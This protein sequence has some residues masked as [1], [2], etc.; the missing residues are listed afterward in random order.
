MAA[1]IPF[2]ALAAT[3]ASTAFS[4]RAQRQQAEATRQAGIQER[5]AAERQAGEEVRVSREEAADLRE[6]RRRTLAR[7]RSQFAAA[8]V[9]LSGSPLE[10]LAET[11]EIFGRDINRVLTAGSQ[12]ASIIRQQ[13][14][15][16]Q[17]GGGRRASAI[18]LAG[19]ASGISQVGSGLQSFAQSRRRNA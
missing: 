10:L 14:R 9:N 15:A 18:R 7:Q 1:A 8:G 11:S 3:L 16:A 12:R 2:I 5:F 17:A 4:V 13:G 6:Q 19:V